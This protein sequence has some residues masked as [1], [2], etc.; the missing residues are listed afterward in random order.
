MKL[1]VPTI[2]QKYK[3]GCGAAGMSMIYKYYGKDVS[4]KEIVKEIGGLAKWGSI[5]TDHA[6]MANRLG[7]KVICHSYWLD[8]FSPADIKASRADL[9]KIIESSLRKQKAVCKDGN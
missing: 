7:F 6:L 2:K 4:E 5:T 1:E 8:Y 3:R 9:I